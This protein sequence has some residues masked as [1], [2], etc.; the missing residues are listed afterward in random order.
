MILRRHNDLATDRIGE[1]DGDGLVT[2]KGDVER[3]CRH[4]MSLPLHVLLFCYS[5]MYRGP[6]HYDI[7]QAQ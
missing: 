5:K 7:A 2:G 4:L 6:K 3:Y 1:S